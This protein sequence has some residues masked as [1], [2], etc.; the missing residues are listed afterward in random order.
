V[1]DLPDIDAG[2]ADGAADSQAVFR[3]GLAAFSRP[4]TVLE[5]GVQLEP[6][7]GVQPAAAALVLALLDQDT[8]LWLSRGMPAAVAGYLRFHTGC[9]LVGEPGMADFALVA[10]GAELPALDRFDAGSA[11]Y[12]DRS[13]TIVVQ[14]AGLN[15]RG[16]WRLSGPGIRGETTVSVTGLGDEFVAQWR[17]NYKRFPQ[18]VDVFLASGAK[19]CGLPRTTRIEA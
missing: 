14:V 5:C 4:G 15:E 11:E 7:S 16:G 8:R 17:R 2:L 19:L 9:V 13:A 3:Q 6:P 10:S 18:G 12:P 1:L